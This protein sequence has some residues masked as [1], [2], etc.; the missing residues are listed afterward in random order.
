[1]DLINQT[2]LY[3]FYG[4]LL[5]KHQK[6]IYEAVVLDDYSVSEVAK[7]EGISRQ[8]V[9]ELVKRCDTILQA[10]EGKLGLVK[11]FLRTKDLVEKI[12]KAGRELERCHAVSFEENEDG[13]KKILEI[14]HLCMEILREL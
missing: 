9:S 3:D 8:S 7:E 4:E 13:K 2:Y 14:D 12:Q 6:R 11:R 1:M 10:Y 5:T